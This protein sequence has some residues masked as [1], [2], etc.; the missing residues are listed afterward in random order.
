MLY[1]TILLFLS[2]FSIY[3]CTVAQNIKEQERTKSDYS[4]SKSSF[5]KKQILSLLFSGKYNHVKENIE[6]TPYPL[7]EIAT[8]LNG[9]C[10]TNVD[11]IFQFESNNKVFSLVIL[12]T[13]EIEDNLES[14]CAG[15]SPSFGMALF[16]QENQIWKL[17]KFN[18]SIKKIG[19]A[20]TISPYKIIQISNSGYAL[21]LRE[22]EFQDIDVYEFVYSVNIDD[23]AKE[24]FSY[25]HFKRINLDEEGI[26]TYQ[27][28]TMNVNSKEKTESFDYY[29]ITLSFKHVIYTDNEDKVLKSFNKN[30]EFIANKY[31]LKQ[32]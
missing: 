3:T 21:S 31:E 30:Y 12:K 7:E 19:Q 14:D 9:L 26:I 22:D 29:P 28:S 16:E 15:C 23:F 18:R 5:E 6:W 27:L 32:E 17:K 11:S 10:Y 1:K 25:P 8:S 13:I 2:S 24:L 4:I 20:G